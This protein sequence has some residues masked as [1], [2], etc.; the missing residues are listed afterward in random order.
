MIP[1]LEGLPTLVEVFWKSGVALGAALCI[2]ALL[3]NKSADAR[4]LVLATTIVAMFAAAIASPALPH[5]QATAPEWFRL[6]N[7]VAAAAYA[8]ASLPAT[9]DDG[10]TIAAA[11]TRSAHS[12]PGYPGNTPPA[13]LLRVPHLIPLFWIVGTALLLARF[14]IGLLGLR[15]LRIA[16]EPENDA[17]LLALLN[18]TQTRSGRIRHVELRQNASIPA[19]VTWG[20]FRPVILV[21]TGFERLSDECRNAVLCHELAHVQ[22]NDFFLR[23]LAE[24]ARALLWFQPLMWIARRQLRLEQ[25]LAC[26][27]LVLAAGGKPSAYARLLLDWDARPGMDSLV[28]IGAAVGMAHRSS[29]KRRLHALLDQ[30]LRRDRV[31]GMAVF[32]TWLLALATALPLA[33]ISVTTA[34]PPQSNGPHPLKAPTVPF[35]QM[36]AAKPA[37]VH[38]SLDR[39]SVV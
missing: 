36:P 29:L 31:A 34:T 3:R 33:A 27:N 8:P 12:E 39:K 21:P 20:V 26:D 15:R 5:L 14:A 16:S 28:A 35:E 9:P 23:A 17:D 37:H 38:I 25:E 24:L 32:A 4:R 13:L 1:S 7:P 11:Q 19:P 22:E 2:N 10:T 18:M 30:N 6:G